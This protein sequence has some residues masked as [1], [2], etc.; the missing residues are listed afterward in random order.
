MNLY[1]NFI[2]INLF[3]QEYKMIKFLIE[4]TKFC[5]KV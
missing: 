3:L 4:L 5:R 2:K 1:N